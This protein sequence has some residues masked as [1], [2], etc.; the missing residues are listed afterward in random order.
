ML[1]LLLPASKSVIS[2]KHARLSHSMSLSHF[3]RPTATPSHARC[4]LRVCWLYC[5]CTVY[6]KVHANFNHRFF[7]V[8]LPPITTRHLA[9]L[10]QSSRAKHRA[11]SQLSLLETGALSFLFT[12]IPTLVTGLYRHSSSISS[13]GSH[14]AIA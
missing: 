14:T 9:Q 8:S 12:K 2:L 6:D 7:E 1:L 3:L 13:I 10:P 5:T 11:R 4:W